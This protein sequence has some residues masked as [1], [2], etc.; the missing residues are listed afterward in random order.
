M[1]KVFLLIL[2]SF[3]LSNVLLAQNSLS[4]KQVRKQNSSFLLT[5]RNWNTE[6]PI[7][8]P[9]FAGNFA[10]GDVEIEGEDGVNPEHPIEPPPG[11]DFGK[12]LSRLF[13]KNWYLKFFFLTRIAYEKTTFCFNLMPFLVE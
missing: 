2:V 13:Q 3:L 9:G 5:N 1:R 6:L 4:K 12:I 10:Y 7:W 11:G 8:V